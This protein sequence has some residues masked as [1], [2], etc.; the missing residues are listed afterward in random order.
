MLLKLRGMAFSP[1]CC[2]G[3]QILA[4]TVTRHISRTWRDKIKR[5]RWSNRPS[6]MPPEFFVWPSR[7][8]SAGRLSVDGVPALW[9]IPVDHT[10]RTTSE[11][12]GSGGGSSSGARR[13]RKRQS[14]E[15]ETTNTPGQ[16][17]SPLF[18]PPGNV[19]TINEVDSSTNGFST[20]KA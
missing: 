1:M 14:A 5:S 19:L 17:L 3:T 18:T 4:P 6:L 16:S 20:V 13:K 15:E 11:A 10:L 2:L 12:S 9:L 7:A 8:V